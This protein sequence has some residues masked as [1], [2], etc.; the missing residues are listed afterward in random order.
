M[1]DFCEYCGGD[2]ICKAHYG[3]SDRLGN[4]IEPDYLEFTCTNKDCPECEVTC[5]LCYEVM[6]VVGYDEYICY[7]PYCENCD[8]IL[9]VSVP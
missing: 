3:S 4:P 9:E 2:I 8:L 1:G 6:Q 5:P 7:T